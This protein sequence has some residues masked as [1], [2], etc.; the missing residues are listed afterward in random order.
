MRSWTPGT[1]ALECVQ[2]MH[3]IANHLQRAMRPPP[4]PPIP[5]VTFHIA[6]DHPDAL[7]ISLYLSLSLPPFSS[8]SPV[9]AA[10]S[11]TSSC[12]VSSTIAP[13]S[14]SLSL[15]PRPSCLQSTRPHHHCISHTSFHARPAQ[16]PHHH[17]RSNCAHAQQPHHLP[18]AVNRPICA[19]HPPAAAAAKPTL[20]S[21]LSTIVGVCVLIGSLLYKIPQLLRVI[22][23]RSAAG[24][25]LLMYT[26]ETIGT[27]FSAVYFARRAFPFASYGESVF[28]MAQN[29]LLIMC[30]V[31]FE[32]LPKLPATIAAIL[33]T[34][35]L[36]LL[37]SNLVPLKILVA[38]QV[39][40]IPILNLARVPQ[41]A[42][43]W[44]RKGT[45]QLSPITL[46]LQLLGNIARIF[47]TIAQV[48][49]P[50]M[51]IGIC[52]ATCFNT[53]LF[54]QW[55]YYSRRAP[56]LPTHSPS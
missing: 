17:H 47:T 29:V 21:L 53:T 28:I 40:S 51:F 10:M 46:G 49:D 45:G 42:L 48:K 54:A 27:T 19:F 9:V 34:F 20:L 44:R 50:L 1:C 7:C 23:H 4:P 43:N 55:I 22:R 56:N 6:I 38:L 24:I 5:F 3:F 25:S 16:L 52:V 13:I 12:F 30:I 36:I 2:A 41:I 26:L 39:C 11:A 37:Y 33:Y 32:Q 15:T 31:L 35:S 14:L 8:S 18:N